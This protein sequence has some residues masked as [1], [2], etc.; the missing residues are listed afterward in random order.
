MRDAPK[1]MQFHKLNN[2]RFPLEPSQFVYDS[3]HPNQ[4]VY[5]CTHPKRYLVLTLGNCALMRMPVVGV[6]NYAEPTVV[7]KFKY[8]RNV[9]SNLDFS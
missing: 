3:T 1:T 8:L 5:D 9:S 2:R 4:F 6:E 7:K